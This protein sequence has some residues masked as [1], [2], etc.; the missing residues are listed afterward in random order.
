MNRRMRFLCCLAALCVTAADLTAQGS[1][2]PVDNN[3]WGITFD[4]KPGVRSVTLRW[5]PQSLT[6]G[7]YQ[8]SRSTDSTS[9]VNRRGWYINAKSQATTYTDTTLA[10]GTVYFY[11]IETLRQGGRGPWLSTA[12][13]GAR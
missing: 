13:D 5:K 1:Q 3:T 7:W 8:V 9:M 6:T 11:S 2:Y 12:R 4:F 10:P